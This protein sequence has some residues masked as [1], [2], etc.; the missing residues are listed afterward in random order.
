MK[1]AEKETDKVCFNTLHSDP[2]LSELSVVSKLTVQTVTV[3]AVIV[4][5]F[6]RVWSD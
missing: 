6:S 1:C 5:P 4:Q 3:D 2:V